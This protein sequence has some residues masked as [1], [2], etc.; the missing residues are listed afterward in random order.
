MN[1]LMAPSTNKVHLIRCLLTENVF[2]QTDLWIFKVIFYK[3]EGFVLVKMK[4]IESEFLS[5]L[6]LPTF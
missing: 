2:S 1:L 6:L 4:I 5:G 3:F